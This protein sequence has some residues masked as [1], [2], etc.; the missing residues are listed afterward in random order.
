MSVSCRI[1]GSGLVEISNV[2]IEHQ[3]KASS[4][5]SVKE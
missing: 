4:V 5:C 2:E 3:T 1:T